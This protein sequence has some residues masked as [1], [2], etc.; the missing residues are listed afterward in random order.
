MYAEGAFES[1]DHLR[2]RDL[3]ARSW[4]AMANMGAVDVVT[5]ESGTRI[6]RRGGKKTIFISGKPSVNGRG[7]NTDCSSLQTD[8]RQL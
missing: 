3:G 6:A 5:K 7:G 8:L 1:V 4:C 2:G